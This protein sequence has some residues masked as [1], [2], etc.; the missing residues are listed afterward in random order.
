MRQNKFDKLILDN[1]IDK[2]GKIVKASVG[3]DEAEFAE[4]IKLIEEQLKK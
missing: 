3:Y 4:L 2:Y 1:L